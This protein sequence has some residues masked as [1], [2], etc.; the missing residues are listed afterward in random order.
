MPEL[1]REILA[2]VR[3]LI[4]RVGHWPGLRTPVNRLWNT[5]EHSKFAIY[6]H[7]N[8]RS[9]SLEA[10]I[11]PYRI[12]WVPTADIKVMADASFDFITATAQVTGGSWDRN[13][14]RVEDGAY[15]KRFKTV[16]CDGTPW[17]QTD[18]YQR[19]VQ[20]IREGR[21]KRYA[22]VEEFETKLE[23]YEHMFAE[24]QNGNY[25][26]QAELAEDSGDNMIGDGGRTLF[27]SLTDHTL[28]RHE[29]AVNIGRDGTFLRNDGR[30]RLALA[31]LAGLDKVPVRIVVRHKKWQQLR[32]EI[33]RTVDELVKDDLPHQD[34]YKHINREFKNKLHRLDVDIRH[35]DLQVIFQNRLSSF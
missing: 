27:P 5:Y 2:R 35:P 23:Q 7:W 9:V 6:A 10:G 15:Y 28:M 19:Q 1:S 20:K 16:F 18:Y 31:H 33:A 17:A 25:K 26:L 34:I 32:D 30:H 11:N 14:T 4:K 8:L 29:I 13:P 21:S 3:L 22:T 12:Y 24:F